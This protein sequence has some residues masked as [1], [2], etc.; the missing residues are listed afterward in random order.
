[1]YTYESHI[2][3]RETISEMEIEPGEASACRW[4][5]EPLNWMRSHNLCR[6][7]GHAVNKQFWW[8]KLSLLCWW[9]GCHK[10]IVDLVEL[11]EDTYTFKGSDLPCAMLVF[12]LLRRIS[13]NIWFHCMKFYIISS[14]EVLYMEKL[15]TRYRR[16]S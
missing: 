3:L 12:D 2:C 16:T 1:M 14:L 6:S 10:N 4:C 5:L 7:C 9:L 8:P 15:P 11:L 13:Y